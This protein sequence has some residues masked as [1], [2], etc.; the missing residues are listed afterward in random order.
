VSH[1]VSTVRDADQILVLV[2]G[3]SPNAAAMTSCCARTGSTPIS[4]AS[5][6]GR[7][8]GRIMK[9]T[10]L[11]LSER[12]RSRRVTHEDEVLGKAYDSRLMRRL[13]GYLRPYRAQVMFAVATIVGNAVLQLA[14]PY[15][16]KIVIDQYIPARDLSGLT[17][18][19]ALYL[20]TLV[21]SFTFEYVQTWTMQVTGQRVMFDLR[22]QVFSHLQRLD[23]R[24][25]DRNPVGRLMTR[26]TT[27]VDVLNE[28]FTSGV[29]VDLRRR[30]H[31]GRHHG[32]TAVDGL[33]AGAGGVFRVA[34]DRA[35]HA[36]VP[37][38][39]SRFLPNRSC[40]DRPHQ[41]LPAG[42][43]HGHVD[44]CSCSGG[45]RVTSRRSTT[46]TAHTAMPT[47]SP[48]STTQ[49]SILPSSS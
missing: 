2:E 40:L 24:F 43:N 15:L 14:P 6:S 23:L 13:I 4:I 46:S 1:R 31:A 26:V 12:K 34:A 20:T 10:A 35:D 5:S 28:L 36:V 37:A 16:T 30:V 21:A 41:C 39:R 7:R 49:S 32:R 38:E 33:A 11:A 48:S 47:C 42:A 22:M 17:V 29:G 18:I 25:Y 9:Q 27:D 19:A 8:V 44:R 45:R 3:Q